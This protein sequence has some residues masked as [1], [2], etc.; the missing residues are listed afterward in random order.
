MEQLIADIGIIIIFAAIVGFIIKGLKQ[1]IILAYILAGLLIGPYGFHLIGEERTIEIIAELGITFLLFVVGLEMNFGK[2]KEVGK[3]V[4]V[5]GILQ[6]ALS[7]LVAFVAAKF[8]QFEVMP[9]IYAGIVVAFSS[10]LLVV[11]WLADKKILE[12]LEGRITVGIL[13]L[14]DV[15][16]I[17]ALSFLFNADHF[18]F[19]LLGLSLLKGLILL[20]TGFI[21]SRYALPGLFHFAA[22]YPELLFVASL[23][24]CFGFAFLALKLGFSISIGAFVAGVTIANIPYSADLHT[25]IKALANFFNTLFFVA[26]GMQIALPSLGK[27]ILPTVIL[28]AIILLVKPVIVFFLCLFLKYDKKTSFLSGI[29]LGQASEFGLI[30]VAQGMILGHVGADMLSLTIL[31]IILSMTFSSYLIKYDTRI[32][33]VLEPWLRNL[34]CI[35][36]KPKESN[37]V[38]KEPPAVVLYGYEDLD[39]GL[40]DRFNSVKKSVLVVDKNP[41]LVKHLRQKGVNCVYGELSDSG[42]LERL[43]PSKTELLISTSLELRENLS[44]IEHFRKLG[45]RAVII[46]AASRVKDSLK[47]YEEGADYVV[48]PNYLSEKQIGVVVEDLSKDLNSVIK[49]KVEHIAELKK[50]EEHL[51]H[52]QKTGMIPI[53]AF[54][55]DMDKYA[56]KISSRGKSLAKLGRK[57]KNETL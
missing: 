39:Q 2:I 45:S 15:L 38:L 33:Y 20:A 36:K 42:L 12:T 18:S 9:S 5:G 23:A 47:L 41:D 52:V 24:L 53:D 56:K 27:L 8:L 49:S 10:T 19:T 43:E 17:L 57:R 54:L 48:L 30:V 22:R 44:V 37:I 11:S 25:R 13:V 34:D 51:S 40:L 4:V 6:V 32:Y 26:L 1:P 16:V 35:F 7:F 46:V 28:L 29:Y 21:L 14:Q 3:V 31:L 50:K 55:K